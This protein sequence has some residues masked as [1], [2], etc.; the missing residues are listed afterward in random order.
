M[1]VVAELVVV[2]TTNPVDIKMINAKAEITSE[3]IIATAAVDTEITVSLP[4]NN[5]E[6]TIKFF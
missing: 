4:R 1:L 6:K 2:T 3:V 5:S